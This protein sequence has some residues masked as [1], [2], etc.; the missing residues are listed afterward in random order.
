MTQD[1]TNNVEGLIQDLTK[2]FESVVY[3]NRY[4]AL[5]HSRAFLGKNISSDE[6]NAGIKVVDTKYYI[7]QRGYNYLKLS[8]CTDSVLQ[9]SIFAFE[10]IS[11]VWQLCNN[12]ELNL[13]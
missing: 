10:L 1:L 12:A 5:I 11:L 7:C 3:F 13:K 8:S 4:L 9:F 6:R 2:D